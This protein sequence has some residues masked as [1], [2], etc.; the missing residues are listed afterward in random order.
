[1]QQEQQQIVLTK[2]VQITNLSA[3]AVKRMIESDPQ[4]LK[5][6]SFYLQVL[7]LK[8]FDNATTGQQAD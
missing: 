2:A 7:N 5:Q 6:E 4:T 3:R 1:M 8:E